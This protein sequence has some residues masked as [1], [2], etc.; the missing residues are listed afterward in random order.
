MSHHN[1]NRGVQPPPLPE[2][3]A[4]RPNDTS[5][6]NN[7]VLND[8]LIIQQIDQQNEPWIR[9]YWR[10]AMGWLYMAICLFDFI[11]FPTVNMLLPAILSHWSIEHTYQP[12]QSLTLQNG[13]MIHLAFGAILGIAAW[14]RGQEKIALISN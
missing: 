9:Q 2:M 8:R 11:I 4:P 3:E 14:T 1:R 13:G 5:V 7:A 6:L 10:P 12:W